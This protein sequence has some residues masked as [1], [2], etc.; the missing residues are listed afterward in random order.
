MVFATILRKMTHQIN[1][2]TDVYS[3]INSQAKRAQRGTMCTGEESAT[4]SGRGEDLSLS[5]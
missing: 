5:S 1:F 4:L 3:I 2:G